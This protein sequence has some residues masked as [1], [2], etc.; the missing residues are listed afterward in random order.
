MARLTQQQWEHA[1]AEYEISGKSY[2]AI[3]AKFGVVESAVRKKAGLEMWQKDKVRP[4]IDRKVN[5]IKELKKIAEESADLSAVEIRTFDKC[6]SEQVEFDL[7]LTR[8][9]TK[10]AAKTSAMMDAA[11]ELDEAEAASRVFRNLKGND[12]SQQTT[13][14][15]QQQQAQ[16]Q[17]ALSPKEALAEI[18]AQD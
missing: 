16:G 18:L 3:A 10:I 13:V 8:L 6:V 12:R 9:G 1:R 2:C 11:A 4:L 7:S 14:N 17:A 15:V 5:N